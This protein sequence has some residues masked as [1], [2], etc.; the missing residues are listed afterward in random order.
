MNIRLTQIIK[1]FTKN[2]MEKFAQ[3]EILSFDEMEKV[4][5]TDSSR[6]IREC[7]S[8]YAKMVEQLLLAQ[9]QERKEAGV[10]VHKRMFMVI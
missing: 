3:E 8:A 7:L 4:L 6:F 10:A 2:V 5:N 1:K 9:K